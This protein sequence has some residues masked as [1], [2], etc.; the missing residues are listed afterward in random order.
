M[1]QSVAGQWRRHGW[2]DD[3]VESVP[4]LSWDIRSGAPTGVDNTSMQKDMTHA[5]TGTNTSICKR[6]GRMHMLERMTSMVDLVSKASY[7]PHLRN[8]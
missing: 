1:P 2:G 7:K 5:P 3:D 4:F 6:L 8:A